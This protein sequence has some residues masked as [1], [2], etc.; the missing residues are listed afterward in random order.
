MWGGLTPQERKG[1]VRLQHGTREM[2]RSGCP[3]KDCSSAEATEVPNVNLDRIPDMGVAFDAKALLYE[4]F[5]P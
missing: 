1:T 5:D 4:V 3:C 2:H